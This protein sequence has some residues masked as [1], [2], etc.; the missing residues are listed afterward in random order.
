MKNVKPKLLGK[1]SYGCVYEP[2]IP[3]DVETGKGVGKVMNFKNANEEFQI[4]EDIAEDLRGTVD[5]NEIDEYMNP[6]VGEC[7]VRL[8]DDQLRECNALKKEEKQYQLIYKH[9]GTDMHKIIHKRSYSLNE[10]LAILKM[11]EKMVC[12]MNIT[13]CKQRKSHMDIKP[14]NILF[15]SSGKDRDNIAKGK[16]LPIDFGLVC[17]FEKIYEINNVNLLKYEYPYFPF[18]FK[19]YVKTLEIVNEIYLKKQKSRKDPLSILHE[20]LKSFFVREP[21]FSNFLNVDRKLIDRVVLEAS[22]N[23]RRYLKTFE[24][25]ITNRINGD[26]T[27]TIDKFIETLRDNQKQLRVET[28]TGIYD[29]F[30]IQMS[31]LGEDVF[32]PYAEKIDVYSLGVTMLNILNGQGRENLIFQ[33]KNSL[34]PK[35]EEKAFE[36]KSVIERCVT[37]NMYERSTFKELIRNLKKINKDILMSHP[38]ENS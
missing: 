20:E 3:C 17:D 33:L 30:F 4:T 35:L 34:D 14:A 26:V 16:L 38:I 37:C 32:L 1:G 10:N 8:S 22:L 31:R 23:H 29:A 18:E 13:F 21:G 15:V 24:A 9:A 12:K 19:L 7:A 36:L 5:E 6:I 27:N 11:L 28:R 25:M 2:N